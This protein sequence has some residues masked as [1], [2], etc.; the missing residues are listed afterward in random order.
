M[1]IGE[2]HLVSEYSFGPISLHFL[3]LSISKFSCTCNIII[4]YNQIN[5]YLKKKCLIRAL[6]KEHQCRR[7]LHFV[8]ELAGSVQ[9]YGQRET[10]LILNEY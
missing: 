4:I 6:P 9:R 3:P 5:V 1:H 8:H 7:V 10:I 2:F